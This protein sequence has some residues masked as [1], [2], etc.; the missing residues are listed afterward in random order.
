MSEEYLHSAMLDWW[1]ISDD[2]WS[3]VNRN[4]LARSSSWAVDLFSRS[5]ENPP[6]LGYNNFVVLSSIK[7]LKLNS[8]STYSWSSIKPLLGIRTSSARLKLKLAQ[9]TTKTMKR[10]IVFQRRLTVPN[11]FSR[12]LKVEWKW[13]KLPATTESRRFTN[14]KIR[15]AN[16]PPRCCLQ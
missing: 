6:A 16:G 8:H 11:Y 15:A 5:L 2:V 9:I 10:I 3:W 7:E 4:S 1:H 13:D 14:N 12:H